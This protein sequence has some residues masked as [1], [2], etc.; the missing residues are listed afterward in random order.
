MAIPY[1]PTTDA[2]TGFLVPL[3]KA[4]HHVHN[5]VVASGFGWPMTVEQARTELDHAIGHLNDGLRDT[6]GIVSA[7]TWGYLTGYRDLIDTLR[8]GIAITEDVTLDTVLDAET[9]GDFR[10]TLKDFERQ[11]WALLC[12]LDVELLGWNPDECD[13]GKLP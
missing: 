8:D 6:Q 3:F 5:V 2:G 7:V 4:V 10:D 13:P 9:L 12:A 11:S 1:N